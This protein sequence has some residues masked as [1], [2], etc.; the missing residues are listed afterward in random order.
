MIP[1]A[2][3][4]VCG[5]P[6]ARTAD[7][8]IGILEPVHSQS[9]LPAAEV[10]AQALLWEPAIN[11][12]GEAAALHPPSF[13]ATE[14]TM[15]PDSFAVT[16]GLVWVEPLPSVLDDAELISIAPDGALL[17]SETVQNAMSVIAALNVTVTYVTACRLP[18]CPE[19]R[20]A[21]AAV[22]P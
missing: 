4:I 9:T 15:S 14:T 16:A 21:A 10:I 22:N 17:N 6:M 1:A 12:N 11:V 18:D 20:H 5:R 7:A 13:A 8:K 19:F 2:I 3:S